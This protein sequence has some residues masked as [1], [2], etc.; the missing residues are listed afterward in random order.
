MDRGVISRNVTEFAHAWA[1]R[2][3]EW[4]ETGQGHVERS[5]ASQFW[6]DLLRA[7]GVISERMDLFERGAKRA[8]T[9]GAGYIDFF[10][11]GVAIG[12]AKF[13]G[14]DLD[15]AH[16]QALDY[17]AG[18]SIGQHEWPKHVLVTDFAGSVWSAWGSRAGLR[19]SGWRRAPTTWTS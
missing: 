3:R 5:Y 4:D 9:G 17:L 1:Q 8:T 18:G 19:S 13:P 10:W 12:E 16:A 7:F 6:T 15:A 14:A 11:S 2:I